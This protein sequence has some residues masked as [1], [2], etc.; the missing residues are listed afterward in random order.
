MLLLALVGAAMRIH[1]AFAFPKHWGFDA[2]WNW[3]YIE[4]LTHSWV[5][6]APHEG[7]SMGHPPFFY[8]AAALLAR[9]MDGA[10]VESKTIA[11][12]LAVA[13]TGLGAIA[14]AVWLVRSFAPEARKRAFLAAALLLFL[15]VH[16]YMSAMLGEEVV[17]ASLASLAVVGVSVDLVRR[18]PLPRVLW[19][20]A[21]WGLIAGLALLTKLSALLAVGAVGLALLVDGLRR[22]ELQR[23]V[24]VAACF[25]LVAGVVGGWPYAR[26]LLSFG[27]LYPHD[28]SVHERMHSMPPGDRALSDYLRL[29]AATL[30]D[31]RAIQPQLVYSVW[32]TTY[33]TL[34]Y[35]AHRHLL[36]RDSRETTQLGTAMLTLAL[37]P[38]LAFGVGLVRGLRRAW[39]TPDGPDTLFLLLVAL[40]LAGYVLFTWRNPWYA[41]LKGSYLLAM[42]VPF[43]WYTSEV[44][45]DWTGG[46][47][48]R[49][50]LVWAALAALFT[51]SMLVFSF[52]LVLEKTDKG[53]GFRWWEIETPPRTSAQPPLAGGSILSG[54]TQPLEGAGRTQGRQLAHGSPGEVK[55]HHA[56]AARHAGGVVPA[57]LLGALGHAVK[58]PELLLEPEATLALKRRRPFG[59]SAV[60]VLTRA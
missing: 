42:L 56:L 22:R 5:L 52:G 21:G 30:L 48:L 37:L 53:P 47:G 12:R 44:L 36:P 40:T 49:P 13:A 15:P 55:A 11:I 46:K 1:N 50:A 35:D 2:N 20:S 32:G 41:T 19:R 23:A 16:V 51:L 25:G 58:E 43:A 59:V 57:A 8:Y 34:W 33:A 7:W 9:G 31:P 6:P 24:F 18:P 39:A 14:C 45:A 54:V 28:L 29:P 10:S 4:R 17:A 3:E 27:Y 60:G 38:T 26:N